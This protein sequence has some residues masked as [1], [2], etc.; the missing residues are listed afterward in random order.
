[1]KCTVCHTEVPAGAAFCHKCGTPLSGTPEPD[2]MMPSANQQTPESAAPRSPSPSPE[3]PS[4]PKERFEQQAA[5]RDRA[6]EPEVEIWQGGYCPKAMIGAWVASG[7]VTVALVVL[8]VVFPSTPMLLAVLAA[9]ALL[10]LFQLVRLIYRRMNVCYRLTNQRFFH[11]QG[12]LRR[13]TDRIEVIDMDDITFEQ[14]FFE[15]LMN[16]GTICISSS[17][18][19]HPELKLVGIDNVKQV[20][21]QLDDVRRAERRRRGLHIEAI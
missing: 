2:A 8:V 20:A 1:M 17:D 14:G 5:P 6:D 15:R 10:W 16:V 13:V 7:L 18:R 4:T 21:E 19:T 11:E 12:I 9:A 3:V